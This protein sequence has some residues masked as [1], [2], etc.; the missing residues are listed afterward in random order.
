MLRV[1]FS[2]SATRRGTCML[3][4]TTSAGI[5]SHHTPIRFGM[6][7]LPRHEG[8]PLSMKGDAHAAP[9][10]AVAGPPGSP[11]RPSTAQSTIR[12][13][14]PSPPLSINDALRLD[15]AENPARPCSDISPDSPR[16]RS[17]DGQGEEQH[18]ESFAT[19][20]VG[21]VEDECRSKTAISL[22][23][24]VAAPDTWSSRPA[25]SSHDG[26]QQGRR[27]QHRRRG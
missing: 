11:V 19:E 18:G 25:C 23:S 27:R 1:V 5:P 4:N 24:Q 6:Y 15:L 13:V 12:A 14:P 20:H 21:N 7:D 2:S 16:V 8:T 10:Q 22:A 3:L 17:E 26:T 9:Q